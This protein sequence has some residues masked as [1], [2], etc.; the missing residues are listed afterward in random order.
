MTQGDGAAV[1]VDSCVIISQAEVAQDGQALGGKGFVQL[2]HVDL[3]QTQAGQSQHLAGGRCGAETH[4][5]G[6][7]AG[8]R[9]A[10]HAG[11]RRQ[12]M[13]LGFG[14]AGQQQGASTIVDARSVACSHRAVRADDALELGKNFHRTGARMFVLADN[15]RIAFFLRQRDRD[16]LGCQETVLLGTQRID[17]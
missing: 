9:H 10:D 12:T 2:D 15:D 1:R 3:R 6:C 13:A 14:L 16:D 8:G 5:A 17:L 4:D 11:A 7:D